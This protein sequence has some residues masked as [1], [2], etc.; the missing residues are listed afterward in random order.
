MQGVEGFKEASPFSDVFISNP[1]RPTRKDP[2]V[3]ASDWE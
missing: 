1:A 2:Q 3:A